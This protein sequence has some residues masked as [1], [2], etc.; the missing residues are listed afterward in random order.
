MNS[1]TRGILQELITYRPSEKDT[2]DM[3]DARAMHVIESAISLLDEIKDELG[4]EEAELLEKR[5]YSS[6][7]NSDVS[8]FNRA[9]Q[10][11]KGDRENKNE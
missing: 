4:A 11:I 10:K 5:F 3:L 7:R 1:K 9:I 8:R 2:L 6:L